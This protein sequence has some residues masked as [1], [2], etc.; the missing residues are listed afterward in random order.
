MT[1]YFGFAISSTMFEGGDDSD[2]YTITRKVLDPE[3]ENFK[4]LMKEAKSCVNRSHLPTISAIKSRFG[5]EIEI[6]ETPP[7]IHLGHDDIIVIA[8]VSGLP[9]LTDRHQYSESEIQGAQIKFVRYKVSILTMEMKEQM[10]SDYME[11]FG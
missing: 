6:P 1:I 3:S 2:F 7:I 4:D 9:R 8:Q 5:I 11:M 10:E